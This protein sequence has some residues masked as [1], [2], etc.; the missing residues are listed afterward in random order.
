MFRK[1]TFTVLFG[2]AAVAFAGYGVINPRSAPDESNLCVD[3]LAE[4]DLDRIRGLCK[5]NDLD[6]ERDWLDKEGGFLGGGLL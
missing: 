3:K 6:K 5:P 2:L 1:T 4:G